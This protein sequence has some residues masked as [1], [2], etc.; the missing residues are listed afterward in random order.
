MNYYYN[1][2]IFLQQCSEDQLSSYLAS[3]KELYDTVEKNAGKVWIKENFLYTE[4][5]SATKNRQKYVYVLHCLENV[6]KFPHNIQILGR[7]VR[8]I[9]RLKAKMSVNCW[10]YAIVMKSKG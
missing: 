10:N 8:S 2:D 7:L 3:F 5:I 6:K 9:L 4:L 1:E